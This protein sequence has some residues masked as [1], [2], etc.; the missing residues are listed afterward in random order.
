[1]TKESQYGYIYSVSGPVVVAENMTGSAM[2]ELARVGTDE[3][4]GEVIKID[5]DRATIQV[6]EETSGLTVGDPVLKTGK[7]LSVELGPGLM[8]NIY[9]GIQR[10]LQAIQQYSQS[11]YIPRGI[12]THA[13][14]KKK[15]WEF[16]PNKNLKIGD[17][18]TGGDI[19]GS[20]YENAFVHTHN[21]ML[22]PR[23]Y[24]KITYIA[25]QGNYTLEDIVDFIH[26]GS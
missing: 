15:Q 23:N 16:V 26:V 1:M 13:L 22:P 17:L 6:Y 11:I 19:F 3:L 2:Y 14:D 5:K 21:I 10:P 18:I 12:D 20:V 8:D 7:P 25:P 24:G 4:V 9:D